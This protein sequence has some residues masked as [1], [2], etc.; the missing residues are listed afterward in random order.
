M[1]TA[2]GVG[3]GG[4]KALYQESPLV[5]AADVNTVTGTFPGHILQTAKDRAR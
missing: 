2:E 3:E 5:T 4:G 1:T